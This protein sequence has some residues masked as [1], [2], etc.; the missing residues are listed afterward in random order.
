MSD[1]QET[2]SIES[3]AT[4]AEFQAVGLPA[5]ALGS[6]P[7]AAQQ[8]ALLNA[9]RFADTYL[10]AGSRLPI[11]APYD[12]ALVDAVCQIAA[13]R[14]MQRRGFNPNTPGDAAIRMGYED[15]V[16]F[17]TRIADGKA[18]LAVMQTEPV[19]NQPDVSTSTPR[20]WAGLPDDSFVGTNTLGL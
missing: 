8:A 10:R 7:V 9:S 14:L 4:L 11:A 20:G 2:P 17:L 3:Y 19:S 15:A 1:L 6:V 18:H 13:W 16:K 5:G 12:P